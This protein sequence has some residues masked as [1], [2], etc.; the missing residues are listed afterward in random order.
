MRLKLGQR[1]RL[2]YR[3]MTIL[4]VITC[5]SYINYLITFNMAVIY[6][7]QSQICDHNILIITNTKYTPSYEAIY[8]PRTYEQRPMLV[9]LCPL[10]L[11]AQRRRVINDWNRQS[12]V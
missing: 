12:A 2:N 11:S 6:N 7:Y 3:F 1:Y 10:P 4:Y 8:T 5:I 9:H